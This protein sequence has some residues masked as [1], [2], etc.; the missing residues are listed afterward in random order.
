MIKWITRLSKTGARVSDTTKCL[1]SAPDVRNGVPPLS[2]C[3]DK[4]LQPGEVVSGSG[5]QRPIVKDSAIVGFIEVVDHPPWR[6]TA[7]EPAN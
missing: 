1:D 5:C 2:S 4:L 6:E 3:I 7:R